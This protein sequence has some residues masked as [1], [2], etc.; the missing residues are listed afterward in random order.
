MIRKYEIKGMSYLSCAVLYDII[1]FSSSWSETSANVKALSLKFKEL[2]PDD[3]CEFQLHIQNR[4]SESIRC[5]SDRKF[6]VILKLTRLFM[7]FTSLKTDNLFLITIILT[8]LENCSQYSSI[9]TNYMSLNRL[10]S[11]CNI[12]NDICIN[13]LQT[14][15][16]EQTETETETLQE[17]QY[18]IMNHI[19]SI[20]DKLVSIPL[21]R[22]SLLRTAEMVSQYII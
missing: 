21:V 18:K 7:T 12:L 8:V 11:V 1:T 6:E 3:I 9:A 10:G 20:V 19:A 15:S 4:L 17:I 22:Y 14:F 2:S 13:V 5:Q 16:P